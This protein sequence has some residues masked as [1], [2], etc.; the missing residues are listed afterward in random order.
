[1]QQ[2]NEIFI[3]AKARDLYKIN[4]TNL[5]KCFTAWALC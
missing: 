1:M 5:K 2:N 3:R 4:R